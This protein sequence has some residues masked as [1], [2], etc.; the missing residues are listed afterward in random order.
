MNQIIKWLGLSTILKLAWY[1]LC[2]A[3]LSFCCAAG[4]VVAIAT[5]YGML[6][7]ALVF[8]GG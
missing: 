4:M 1:Y 8:M 2:I 5:A 6:K 3:I 7:D